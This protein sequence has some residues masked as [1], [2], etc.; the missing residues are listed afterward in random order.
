MTQAACA[1]PELRQK[2]EVRRQVQPLCH[3]F[4]SEVL[5]VTWTERNI[6][7][8]SQKVY[9]QRFIS[10]FSDVSLSRKNHI[11][12]FS[13]FNKSCSC[14]FRI[15][16]G[17]GGWWPAGLRLESWI[18]TENLPG[19][20]DVWLPAMSVTNF[21]SF[22]NI[23]PFRIIRIVKVL[24]CRGSFDSDC[25][26]NSNSFANAVIDE[27]IQWKRKRDDFEEKSWHFWIEGW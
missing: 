16:C 17:P 15:S 7:L 9:W 14:L 5:H 2:R 26:A 18:S 8:T 19:A 3:G 25:A 1:G 6:S 23:F 27:E 13:F 21:K 22:R 11:K 12:Q 4:V 10:T 24:S 20:T